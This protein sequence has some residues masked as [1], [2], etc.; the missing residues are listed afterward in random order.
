MATAPMN[1]RF[2]WQTFINDNS[3]HDVMIDQ[4]AWLANLLLKVS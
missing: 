2:G 3:G 1:V 4:P